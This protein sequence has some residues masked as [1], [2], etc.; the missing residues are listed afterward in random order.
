MSDVKLVG[1]ERVW[2]KAFLFLAVLILGAGG[3]IGTILPPDPFA[4][5]E[6]VPAF[7]HVFVPIGENVEITQLN[8]SNA[9]YIIGTIKPESAW[10]TGY[11]AV[12]HPSQPNYVAMT[13]GTYTSCGDA[14]PSAACDLNVNNLFQ[15][16]DAT[17]VSWKTWA[18]SMPLACSLGNAGAESSLNVYYV[19]HNPAVYYTYLVTGGTTPTSE[20]T[21]NVIPAGTTG[22]NDISVFNAALSS[23]N[24]PRF[25]YVVPNGCEDG[26]DGDCPTNG[27][28]RI[29]NF[30]SFLS[31][32]IPL[33]RSSSAYGSDGVIF[34][35]YDEGTTGRGVG[36]DVMFAVISPLVEVNQYG[37]WFD[38]Y[39]F[40]RTMED[41]FGVSGYLGN[42]TTA[43]PIN[44]IWKS[45][46]ITGTT[47]TT[48]SSSPSI[49]FAGTTIAELIT[50]IAAAS[51]FLF[52]V[53]ILRRRARV[54][55]S[56]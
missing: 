12:A 16:L 48:T 31:R 50:A 53:S 39:G 5:S 42:A 47:T 25:N 4:A 34:I 40:L 21:S 56:E 29:T 24:V 35:T 6:G 27:G 55:Q 17:G 54:R 30:D 10:L 11:F 1:R 3:T 45:T 32:E 22:P 44:M 52:A 38:H 26:H 14:D 19:R 20:C 37:G 46:S 43:T 15:Q 8:A 51:V 41:G 7:G 23:G 13:S 36:G 18:E 9:P 33:I 28:N 2:L 49:T